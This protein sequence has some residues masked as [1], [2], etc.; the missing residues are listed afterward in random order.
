[1]R[2]V[3]KVMLIRDITAISTVMWKVGLLDPYIEVWGS[4]DK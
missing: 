4:L 2:N 3:G 1:M